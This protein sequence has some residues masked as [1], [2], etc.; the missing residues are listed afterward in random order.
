MILADK[1]RIDRT[2]KRMAYQIAEE[3]HGS[4]IHLAGLNQRGFALAKQLQASLRNSAQP[5]SEVE[6][7]QIDAIGE[8]MPPD[9]FHHIKDCMLVIV[10]DVI[11]SGSTI[12][13]AIE[14]MG[15]LERFS[16]VMVSVLIDRGHRKYPLQAA[17]IGMNIPTK[18][19]E[20]ITVELSNGTPEKVVLSI[21]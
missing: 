9:E 10:D 6:F 1:N 3:A 14:K 2:V 16:R 12:M 17:V 11:F 19:D 4:K 21:S 20:Q 18:L 5:D 7:T 13:K 15:D 8:E